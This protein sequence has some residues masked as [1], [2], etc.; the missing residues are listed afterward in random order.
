VTASRQPAGDCLLAREFR[1]P[2]KNVFRPVGR[3]VFAI[4]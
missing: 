3:F 2:T 1:L 4:D